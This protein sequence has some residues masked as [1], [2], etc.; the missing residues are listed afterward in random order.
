MKAY[1]LAKVLVARPCSNCGLES[2]NQ[3]RPWVPRVLKEPEPLWMVRDWEGHRKGWRPSSLISADLCRARGQVSNECEHGNYRKW[4]KKPTPKHSGNESS[5]KTQ[6]SGD[7]S[8]TPEREKEWKEVAMIWR[9][10]GT[11]DGWPLV[12]SEKHKGALF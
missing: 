4:S 1:C 3:S 12:S 9:G 6:R 10:G 11:S 8:E 2:E 7:E 5:G